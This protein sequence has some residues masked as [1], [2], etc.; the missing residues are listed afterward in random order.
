MGR[1]EKNTVR[2]K[3]YLE[4]SI[5]QK[6]QREREEDSGTHGVTTTWEASEVVKKLPAINVTVA[7][8]VMGS[9]DV[10]Q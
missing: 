6:K 7:N 1:I 2:K 10:S 8:Q 4:Y 5:D 9:N 3:P